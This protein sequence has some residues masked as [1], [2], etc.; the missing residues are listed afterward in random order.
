MSVSFEI[1]KLYN[2]STRAPAILGAN[3]KSVKV[4]GII[5]YNLASKYI[6]PETQHVNIY[7][8]LPTGTV[9]DPKKY[10]YVLIQTQSGDVT[11]LAMPWID[12]T[13]IALVASR[14][15]IITVR[16]VDTGD[17]TVIRDNLLLMGFSDITIEIRNN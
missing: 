14:N 10:T 5:D 13:S 9:N 4:L 16:D 3:F 2:F 6:N 8:Y 11:V 15:L 1:H 17:D 7:P 12:E